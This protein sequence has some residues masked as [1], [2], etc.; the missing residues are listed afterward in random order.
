MDVPAALALAPRGGSRHN[1]NIPH[2]QDGRPSPSVGRIEVSSVRAAGRS[3]PAATLLLRSRS[4]MARTN[5]K[6]EQSHFFC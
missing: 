2:N 4:A 5:A 1:V 3:R 6:W